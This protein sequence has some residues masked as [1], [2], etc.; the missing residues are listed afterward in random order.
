MLVLC[1]GTF[2]LV[3]EALKVEF[4]FFF[5]RL[6]T[7]SLLLLLNPAF[8]EQ[9]FSLDT[10]LLKGSKLRGEDFALLQEDDVSVL[11]GVSYILVRVVLELVYKLH[12]FEVLLLIC[13]QV[14]LEI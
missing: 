2:P 8:G 9:A 14:R 12:N 13:L 11:C 5:F 1:S 7:R 3:E 10:L 6:A 4:V